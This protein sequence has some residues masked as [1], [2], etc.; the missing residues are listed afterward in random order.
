MKKIIFLSL[1]CFLLA[2]ENPFIPTGELNT[3]VV[4]TNL[5]QEFE[6]FSELKISLDKGDMLL[7]EVVLYTVQK[8]GSKR[9]QTIKVNKSIDASEPYVLTSAKNTV[10]KPCE[11]PPCARDNKFKHNSTCACCA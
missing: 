6:P 3:D 1:A 7:D 2:R 8:D 11:I 9:K 4:V 5:K 10:C